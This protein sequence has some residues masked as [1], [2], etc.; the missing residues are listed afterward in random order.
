MFINFL[1]IEISQ[2]IHLP[3]PFPSYVFECVSDRD[4]L[5]PHTIAKI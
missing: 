4:I 1:V 3:L 2:Y 5:V